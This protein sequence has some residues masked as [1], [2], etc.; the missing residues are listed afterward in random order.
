[1][2][3][4]TLTSKPISRSSFFALPDLTT[5]SAYFLTGGFAGLCTLPIEYTFQSISASKALRPVPFLRTHIPSGLYRPAIRFWVFSLA[6]SV[7]QQNIPAHVQTIGTAHPPLTTHIHTAVIGGVSGACGGFSEVFVQSLLVHRNV[8]TF[9]ALL[10]QS[11]KLFL[12]FG[13]YTFVSTRYSATSPPRPFWKC[14][15]MGATAGAVG[16]AV[17]AGVEGLRGTRALMTAAGKGAC[18]IGTVIS[19]QVTSCHWVLESMGV[20]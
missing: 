11:S 13:T 7:L 19:V 17:M 15:V 14:W 12:C 1:M 9:S 4:E 16:S 10:N 8:P 3:H 5:Q 2:Q 6:R 20:L 18:L